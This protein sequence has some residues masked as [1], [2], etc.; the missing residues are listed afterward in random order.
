MRTKEAAF[1]VSLGHGLRNPRQ[2]NANECLVNWV[3]RL[4]YIVVSVAV[5]H[6]AFYM[7]ILF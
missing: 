5:V 6:E 7:M 3:R 4:F 1:S 2:I